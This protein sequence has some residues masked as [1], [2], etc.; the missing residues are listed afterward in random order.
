LFF[1]FQN[2]ES[3]SSVTNRQLVDT[4]NAE[5]DAERE[6]GDVKTQLACAQAQATYQHQEAANEAKALQLELSATTA[7]A[8][9]LSNELAS[10]KQTLEQVIHTR[11]E[12][13]F[14][15]LY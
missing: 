3:I 12:T 4:T 6:L 13:I 15:W 2:V 10:H 7:R 14:K 1:A 8:A 11:Y 9:H 5:L